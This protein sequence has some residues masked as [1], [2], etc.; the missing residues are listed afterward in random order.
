MIVTDIMQAEDNK[1]TTTGFMGIFNID[2]H[3]AAML[4]DKIEI[5]F[6]EK[7][8]NDL[9]SYNPSTRLDS[10]NFNEK[11]ITYLQDEFEGRSM[12]GAQ[13]AAQ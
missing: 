8:I 7:Q 13:A 12:S 3:W 5:K 6:I 11:L 10:L 9:E 4:E 2:D 1:E